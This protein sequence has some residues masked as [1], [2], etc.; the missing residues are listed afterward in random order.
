MVMNEKTG[1][2]EAVARAEPLPRMN[3]KMLVRSNVLYI[4]G[5]LLEIGDR[6]VT[7]DDC[8][9]MDLRKR[10]HWECL[11][12]G[13]IHKQV[14]R[15]A[16]NDDD[17]SYISTA[18]GADGDSDDDDEFDDDEDEELDEEAQK[19]A[20]KAK[21]AAKKEKKR[22]GLKQEIAELN[23]QLDLGDTNR[24]PAMREAMAD[25][26][27]R[28]SEFWTQQAAERVS[29]HQTD[30]NQPLS[31]KEMKRGGFTLAQQRYDEL[32]PILDRLN[33]LELQQQEAEGDSSKQKGEKK[34]EKKEKKEKDKKG[35]GKKGK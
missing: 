19:E 31:H 15:G 8:W 27:S 22:N 12:E 13:T 23:S 32:R 21:K 11:W 28:T 4:Y 30:A 33:E 24:T 20:K 16:I 7:L 5:G 6:E 9:A 3:A 14:W 1:A 18:T 2:P 25:F 35:R 29:E 17:D 34:G 26:Y 10:T